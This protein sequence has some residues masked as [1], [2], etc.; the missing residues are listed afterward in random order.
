MFSDNIIPGELTVH[1]LK[2]EELKQL[3]KN[4]LNYHSD[5]SMRLKKFIPEFIIITCIF[6][7]GWS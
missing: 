1:E 2:N 7:Y 3:E 5:N 6:I 4:E